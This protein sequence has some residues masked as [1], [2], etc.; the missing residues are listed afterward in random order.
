[1]PEKSKVEKL[2]DTVL[3]NASAV[4]DVASLSNEERHEV[5]EIVVF[6]LRCGMVNMCDEDM[7]A[8]DILNLY[9]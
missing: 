2:A 8:Q 6:R 1:M 5:L 4:L 7:S 3:S 9:P